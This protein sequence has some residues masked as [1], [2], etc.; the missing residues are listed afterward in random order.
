MNLPEPG[1]IKRN[2]DK[3]IYHKDELD[4]NFQVKNSKGGLDFVK[5]A[6][7]FADALN[8]KNQ[9]HLDKEITPDESS[10]HHQV[11]HPKIVEEEYGEQPH[12]EM[13]PSPE[14]PLNF[15]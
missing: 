11:L 4:P 1:V 5:L 13:F 12:D 8:S 10:Y 15:L 2:T 7:L 9:E 6:E 3:R 14:N